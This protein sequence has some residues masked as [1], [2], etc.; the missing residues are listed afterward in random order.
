MVVAS[1]VESGPTCFTIWLALGWLRA[2]EAPLNLG[3]RGKLLAHSLSGAGARILV[4]D[5]SQLKS[6]IAVV[7]DLPNLR[8]VVVIGLSESSRDAIQHLARFDIAVVDS[9]ELV[10][11][12]E[13]GIDCDGPLYRDAAALLYTSGTTGPSKGVLVPWA[14]VHQTWSWVPDDAL[15]PGEGVYCPF[16]MFHISGKSALNAAL[17]RGGRF[18]WRDRFSG[19]ELWSDIIRNDCVLACLVGPMLA[20]VNSQPEAVTDANNPLRSVV[21]GPMIP[22]IA[23]FEERFGVRVATCY[24]MTELGTPLATGWDHGPDL[25]CGHVR[26]DYP[27]TEV[28]VVDEFD[29]PL[30]PGVVGELVART[31]EPWA[32]NAGYHDEPDESARAWR[33]GWFHSGDA[34]Y[35]DD[36]GW[37]YFV[38]RMNDT[39][40]RRGENISSFEVEQIVRDYPGVLDCAA[41]GVDAEHGGDEVLIVVEI[42]ES[43]ELDPGLLA[44]WL[45]P[46]LP[47]HMVPR[48]V[49][50]VPVLPRNE[51]SLRIQ[52]FRLREEGVTTDTWDRL[53][54]ST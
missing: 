47:R 23:R 36:E 42:A 53:K 52:K 13:A 46:R 44:D 38:D 4:A 3:L 37:F 7:S 45:E 34:F 40:R 15:A 51:T 35:F 17:V 6:L 28:R 20:F 1:M 19:S 43:D 48:F 14:S 49:R 5:E 33:N 12:E 2:V 39:I 41:V 22:N 8:L 25:T 9:T 31:A 24:S 54:A 29:Q 11:D 21:C 50:L 32:L 30:G 10:M 26:K 18:V 27:Q 16:P